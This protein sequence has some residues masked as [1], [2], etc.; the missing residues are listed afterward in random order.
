[1]S[2]GGV[3][4]RM[5]TNTCA[6]VAAARAMGYFLLTVDLFTISGLRGLNFGDYR[7]LAS[8]GRARRTSVHKT[9]NLK[10]FQR[11]AVRS[12]ITLACGAADR[13]AVRRVF[14]AALAGADELS[15][16]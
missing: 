15:L 1:M 5:S 6:R 3:N 10:S 9:L 12:V 4:G 8:I 2:I 7:P 14:T 16:D 11:H 13:G